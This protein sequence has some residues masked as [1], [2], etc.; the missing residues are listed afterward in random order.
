MRGRTTFIIAHRLN[1]LMH[2]DVLLRLEEGRLI[3][4]KTSDLDT[5]YAESR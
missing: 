3:E 2:C 5:V 1:T 4:I